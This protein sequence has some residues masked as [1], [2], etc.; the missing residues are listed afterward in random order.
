[1]GTSH[2]RLKVHRRTQ[3]LDGRGYTVLSPRPNETA[4]FATD[5]DHIVTDADGAHLLARLCWAM[6]FQRRARTVV[7]IDAG[8]WPIAIVN[9]ELGTLGSAALAD[10]RATLPFET[11]SDGTV[12]LQTRGLDLALA[13]PAA[14]ARRDDQKGW[15]E[16]YGIRRWIG[17]ASGVLVIAAPPPVLLGWGVEL[18]DLGGRPAERAG[19]QAGGEVRILE[20]PVGG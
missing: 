16:M 8:P 7:V 14:F 4:P 11:P 13:D 3:K 1:M 17:E 15:R 12:V 18:S 9:D 19:G 6:A 2:E 20:A 10:L 5:R